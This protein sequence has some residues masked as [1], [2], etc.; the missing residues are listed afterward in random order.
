MGKTINLILI[1]IL[2]S[3][4]VISVNYDYIYNPYTAKQDRSIKL[5]QSGNNFTADYFI[6]DGSQLTG[7][8][9]GE[10]ILYFLDKPSTDQ[11]GNRTLSSLPNSTE[12]TLT[13]TSL[14]DGNTLMGTWITDIGVPNINLL[15]GNIGVHVTGR[16]SGGTKNAQYFFMAYKTDRKSVV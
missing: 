15:E 11:T 7:I 16:K 14:P 6:G 1:C 4:I 10:L 5:N 2:C 13:G 3:T 8:E 12:V 9:Q